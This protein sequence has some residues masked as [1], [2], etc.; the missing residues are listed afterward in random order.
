MQ[1]T[2]R[3]VRKL[4][5]MIRNECAMEE[6]TA[7]LRMSAEDVAKACVKLAIKPALSD[8]KLV[9]RRC[10]AVELRERGMS[11]KRIGLE[12][13]VSATRAQL[14]VLRYSPATAAKYR[15]D[16]AEH[17]KRIVALRKEGKSYAEVATILNVSEPSVAQMCRRSGDQSLIV[18]PSVRL[19]TPEERAQVLKLRGD[20][21]TFDDIAAK[22]KITRYMIRQVVP[23]GKKPVTK[24]VSS[25]KSRP[26]PEDLESIAGYRAQH[27]MPHDIARRVG[28]PVRT[29]VK[30]LLETTPHAQ[31]SIQV[32]DAGFAD[33]DRGTPHEGGSP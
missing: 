17:F 5:K 1:L 14:L 7:E 2:A 15:K 29:V 3:I 23:A 8:T 19:L 12:L 20:G 30:I 10:Q 25:T 13:G 32:P 33:D 6:I 16:K 4:R 22:L 11:Y 31:G 18:R 26:T 27:L 24:V 21:M 9:E 28:L